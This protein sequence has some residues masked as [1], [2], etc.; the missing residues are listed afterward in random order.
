[1]QQRPIPCLVEIKIKILSRPYPRV[2]AIT[3]PPVCTLS[4]SVRLT[5][6]SNVVQ[7]FNGNANIICRKL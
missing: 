2:K 1:M 6:M 4:V 7:A 5:Y 3:Q